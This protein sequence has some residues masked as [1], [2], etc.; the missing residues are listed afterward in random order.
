MRLRRL[1]QLSTYLVLPGDQPRASA[2]AGRFQ[3]IRH[4]HRNRQW[5]NPTGYRCHRSRN[6]CDLGVDISNED[7]TLLRKLS[8]A[9]SISADDRPRQ[10]RIADTIN[11]DIDHRSSGLN[12][13]RRD[14]RRTSDCSDNDVGTTAYSRQVSG[15]RVTDCH[16]GVRISQQHGHWLTDNITPADYHCL[17]PGDRNIAATQYF[18]HACRRAGNQGWMIRGKVAHTHRMQTIDI[19]LRIDGKKHSSSVDRFGKWQLNEDAIDIISSV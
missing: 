17:L 16:R 12:E 11:S 15:L 13:V 9:L 8:F 4:Q 3:C 10:A 18:H 5:S 6:F 19:F 2:H 14:H 1:G 7:I